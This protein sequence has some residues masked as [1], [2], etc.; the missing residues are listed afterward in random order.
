MPMA[1]ALAR[2]VVT[3]PMTRSPAREAMTIVK[4]LAKMPRMSSGR[5]PSKNLCTLAASQM[6]GMDGRTWR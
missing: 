4:T 5:Q 3:G 1:T 2:M 6:M